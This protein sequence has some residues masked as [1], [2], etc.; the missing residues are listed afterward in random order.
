MSKVTIIGGGVSGLAAGIYAQMSGLESEIFEGHTVIGGQ[1]T[2]WKRKG[3]HIDNCVHWMTGT[4]P[5]KE[6]HQVW[7]DV[8]V[9]GE[10]CKM[11][12]HEYF[13]QVDFDGI[14]G[15]AWRD[16]NKMESELLSIAPEDKEL[17]HDL[18]KAIRNFR[19]IELPAL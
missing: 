13:M 5:E 11:I 3:F 7:K 2:S 19:C 1:C 12:E 17:I 14:K 8:G 9:I 18:I 16:L 4:S 6:I 15:H 10:G